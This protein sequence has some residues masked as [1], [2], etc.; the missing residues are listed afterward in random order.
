MWR[1]TSIPHHLTS[2]PEIPTSEH[3]ASTFELQHPSLKDETWTSE[4]G[5]LT[6]KL[7]T[8]TSVREALLAI[9][10]PSASK[11]ETWTSVRGAL[12]AILETSLPKPQLSRSEVLHP[13]TWPS[14]QQCHHEFYSFWNVTTPLMRQGSDP[15]SERSLRNCVDW[16]PPPARFQPH[17]GHGL[18][19]AKSIAWHAEAYNRIT[20]TRPKLY[21][22][23]K[24]AFGLRLDI[25]TTEIFFSETVRNLPRGHII[26]QFTCV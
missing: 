20:Q 23:I 11:L 19:L 6:F 26:S 2:K 7:Q 25:C 24:Q 12:L 13:S 4:H 14:S 3:G 5:T 16:K 1:S 15:A 9:L 8:S 22:F 10:Q 21:Q 17:N 18:S